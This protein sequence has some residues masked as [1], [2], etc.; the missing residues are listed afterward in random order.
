LT[1]SESRA[2]AKIKEMIESP[3][4]EQ[5]RYTQKR[6]K[7][8]RGYKL[9]LTEVASEEQ[10]AIITDIEIVSA[11]EY[12]GESLPN[13][14]QRLNER[15]ILPQTHLVDTGYVSGDAIVESRERGV[16]LLGPIASNTTMTARENEG[17]SV[18]DFQI[19]FE[20]K[21][22]ICPNGNKQRCFSETVDGR[23]RK[24]FQ[25]LWNKEICQNCPFK[26][27][28]IQGKKLGRTIKISRNY[29]VIQQRRVEQKTDDFHNRYR[30]RAGVEATFSHLVSCM[31]ARQTP[32][33]GKNKTQLHFLLLAAGLNIKRAVNWDN[34]L[35]PQLKR[36]SR[37]QT[38]S[39]TCFFHF[40]LG[41]FSYVFLLYIDVTFD[42]A[43]SN[44]K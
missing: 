2:K 1:T 32:Y 28:C 14:H 43:S 40:R 31:G 35:R 38:L 15:E 16:E 4:D 12:D 20:N 44:L 21:Q 41:S 10:V 23:G 17:F 18:E 39:L 8:Y 36:S 33:R 37:L 30:R 11:N 22:A 5:T 19:D 42:F 7:E 6:G 13:I 26:D 25:I 9:Q 34:G 29:K 24:V 27:K 3:H